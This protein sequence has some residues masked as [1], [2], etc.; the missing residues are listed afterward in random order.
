M[1]E[2]TWDQGRAAPSWARK[3]D[4]AGHRVWPKRPRERRA[5]AIGA[6]VGN[7]L[8]LVIASTYP[9]WGPWTAGVV[10]PSFANVVWAVT[11]TCVV[12]MAGNTLLLAFPTR[13]LKHVVDLVSA[14]ASLL[15]TAVVL[16]VFPFAFARIGLPWVDLIVWIVL[17]AALIGIAVGL[18]VRLV[19][20][21]FL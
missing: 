10:T 8:V 14:S 9:S 19:R 11:L 15:S 7:A 1:S 5:D 20:F 12:T 13:T 6:I 18:C 21:A 3:V 4:E 2:R 16:S 17:L